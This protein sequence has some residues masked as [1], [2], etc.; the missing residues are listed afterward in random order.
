KADG[1]EPS[2]G[3]AVEFVR[4]LEVCR[5]EQKAVICVKGASSRSLSRSFLDYFEHP[6]YRESQKVVDVWWI[7][8]DGGLLAL[9][10][11]LFTTHEVWVWKTT[12]VRIFVVMEEITA[13]QAA[14]AGQKLE[15]TLRRKRLFQTVEVEVVVLDDKMIEPYTYDWTLRYEERAQFQPTIHQAHAKENVFPSQLDDLF[16]DINA[17]DAAEDSGDHP[18]KAKPSRGSVDDLPEKSGSRPSAMDSDQLQVTCSLP[19]GTTDG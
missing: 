1:S 17:N 2:S 3:A 7:I 15:N 18:D 19:V 8:H 16:S 13:E 12:R 9:L 5:I 10:A 14:A 11:W 6:G 4:T